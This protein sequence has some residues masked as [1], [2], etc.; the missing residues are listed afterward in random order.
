MDYGAAKHT[1]GCTKLLFDLD[2]ETCKGEMVTMAN[3]TSY[4]VKRK[5]FRWTLSKKKNVV[6]EI[7]G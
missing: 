1:T 7:T 2:T 3:K 5:H 6:V 4:E